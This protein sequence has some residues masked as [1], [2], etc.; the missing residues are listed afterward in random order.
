MHQL[1][2]W[3]EQAVRQHAAAVEREIMLKCPVGRDPRTALD[4]KIYQPREPI[5]QEGISFVL[6]LPVV[7]VEVKP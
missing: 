2:Q 3:I 6:N 5:S 4:V 1:S 7:T